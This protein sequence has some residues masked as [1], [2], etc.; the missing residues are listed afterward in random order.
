MRVMKHLVYWLF[1]LLWLVIVMVF[2][3]SVWVVEA[4]SSDCPEWSIMLNTNFPFLWRCI[5]KEVEGDQA[6]LA[7]VFPKL[8]WVLIR[9]L[10][11]IILVAWVL[12][13]IW[14][15][16]MIAWSGTK[17]TSLESGKWLII[18]VIVGLILL[19]TSALILNLINPNFF[20]ID[21]VWF[22]HQKDDYNNEMKKF[23]I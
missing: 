22:N 5:R 20:G 12:L 6:N 7:N 15:W 11:T 23:Y 17:I 13:I 4:A 10:M 19:G 21:S 16:L 1:G 9:V 14:W 18:K 3:Q 2:W 8:M